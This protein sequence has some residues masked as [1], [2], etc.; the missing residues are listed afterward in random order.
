MGLTLML[1]WELVVSTFA[2]DYDDFLFLNLLTYCF[3]D[4]V[5]F[6]HFFLPVKVFISQL[7]CRC[8]R[9]SEVVFLQLAF[10]SKAAARR[11]MALLAWPR[12]LKRVQQQHC[13][14]FL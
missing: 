1:T 7:Q 6:F 11:G 10:A 3:S 12:R 13:V 2:R 14:K 5:V 4:F 9:E 8:L